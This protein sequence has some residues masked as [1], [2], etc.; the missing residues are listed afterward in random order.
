M[1]PKH[2]AIISDLASDI[3]KAWV[4]W[5]NYRL[6]P[7]HNTIYLLRLHQRVLERAHSLLIWVH[8]DEEI[9]AAKIAIIHHV[10]IAHSRHRHADEEVIAAIFAI[11]EWEVT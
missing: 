3:V 9:E 6:K 7:R 2:E 11:L 10:T 1:M 5:D 4:D 8:A